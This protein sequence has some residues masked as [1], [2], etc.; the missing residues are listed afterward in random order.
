MFKK[1]ADKPSITKGK[2]YAKLTNSSSCLITPTAKKSTT[3]FTTK[4]KKKSGP[5]TNSTSKK[6]ASSTAFYHTKNQA[7]LTQ[8]TAKGKKFNQT[9]GQLLSTVNEQNRREETKASPTRNTIKSKATTGRLKSKK[10]LT[11][12]S[13]KTAAGSMSHF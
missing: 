13:S 10:P 1:I 9:S 4:K 8:T 3:F 11:S 7:L 2:T 5:A 6:T 12:R